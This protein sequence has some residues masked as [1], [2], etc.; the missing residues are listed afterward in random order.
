[1][2]A[3]YKLQTSH[4]KV[5]SNVTDNTPMFFHSFCYVA[6]VFNC[7]HKSVCVSVQV[8]EPCVQ[9]TAISP[10]ILRCSAAPWESP[11]QTQSFSCKRSRGDRCTSSPTT[12]LQ[13]ARKTSTHSFINI[14]SISECFWMCI[15]FYLLQRTWW[16]TSR[17]SFDHWH[18]RR[19]SSEILPP[20][21]RS[22]C[23][24]THKYI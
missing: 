13:H 18:S 24:E 5:L 14:I 17:F 6:W 9:S 2:A 21:C 1:M 15:C 7:G 11:P 23:K 4:Q 22:T 19:P 16:Y 3:N 20:S 10:D 8:S 12:F